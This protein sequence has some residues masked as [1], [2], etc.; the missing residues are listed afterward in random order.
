M[1]QSDSA[2]E[3]SA[4]DT[5]HKNVVP[6]GDNTW[7]N[8]GK[9][10]QKPDVFGNFVQQI[11]SPEVDC[12][13]IY[14]KPVNARSITALEFDN[15]YY[16]QTNSTGRSRELATPV[17]QP[18]ADG[19]PKPQ[20][21]RITTQG[22]TMDSRR[23]DVFMHALPAVRPV[24]FDTAHG[25]KS[26]TAV[27]VSEDGLMVTNKHVVDGSNGTLNVTMLGKDGKE[28]TRTA[29]VVKVEGKQ[30]LALLQ[31]DRKPGETFLALPLSKETSWRQREPLVEMG[32]AN[33]EGKISMAKSRYED[34]VRQSDIPFDKQ[35][36]EVRQG[37]TM[38]KLE[39]TVPHGYSGGVVLSV[40]GSERRSDGQVH[41]LGTSAIRAIT[42]YSDTDRTAYVIPAAR[43][44][45]LLD[46]YR[47]D[48]A[49]K[50]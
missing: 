44:Q 14:S 37:R 10:E 11:N 43:V 34:M 21:E 42:D 29:R 18:G 27:T 6:V 20:M 5:K 30:D 25:R 16:G 45:E 39:A 35:P 9:P 46:Q 8:T 32:N 2:S 49:K 12:K 3:R 26:G 31:L 15:C 1:G 33:G 24:S 50:K 28:E 38:F 41:R 36:P 40:P 7:S 17:M 47:R 48:Q 23:L 4:D 22:T 13:S 19:V